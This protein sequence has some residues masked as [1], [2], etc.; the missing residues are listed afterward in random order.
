LQDAEF[1]YQADIRQPLDD[2]VSQLGRVM[3]IQNLGSLQDKTQRLQGLSAWLVE[4]IKPGS[5]NLRTLAMDAARLSKADLITHMIQEKEYNGL[6]GLMGYYYALAQGKPRD[7]AVALKEQ[8][9]PRFQGDM[10]AETLP[11]RILAMADKWDHLV[12]C[13]SAGFRPSGTKDPYALRR[14]V[15]GAVATLL[16][17][18]YRISLRQFTL[19]A[20][21]QFA[22]APEL[23]DQIRSE[24]MAFIRVRLE[25]ELRAQGFAYDSVRAV[26]NAPWDD[27]VAVREKIRALSDLRKNLAFETMLGTFARVLNILPDG[28]ATG[29]SVRPELFEHPA[30]K[31][32]HH[33]VSKVEPHIL[34]EFQQDRYVSGLEQLSQLKPAIDAFFEGVLVMDARAEIRNN[35]LALLETVAGLIRTF[36][37]FRALGVTEG[38]NSDSGR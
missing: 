12:G 25:N 16:A 15:L 24:I 5:G 10:I 28:E 19:E 31:A 6:Q 22:L 13:W 26:L 20:C 23:S 35:R 32:L 37:D 30:E 14:G 21:R 17:S 34:R 11:G 8:Y 29:A 7:L 27:V 9:L 18:G 33:A 3:W 2:L 1:F 4:Q 38:A 36:A